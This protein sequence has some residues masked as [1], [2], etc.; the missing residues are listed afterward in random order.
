MVRVLRAV[1][2]TGRGECLDFKALVRSNNWICRT[3]DINIA[4]TVERA[5]FPD[6]DF[7]GVQMSIEDSE[8]ESTQSSV[9]RHPRWSNTDS[10]SAH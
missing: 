8:V 2:L 3:H 1:K 5:F 4:F 7:V 9:V 6:I 10:Q